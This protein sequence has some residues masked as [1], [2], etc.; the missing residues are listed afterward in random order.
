MNKIHK[1]VT[2]A[3]TFYH[4][5]LNQRHREDGPA[6]IYNSGTEMWYINDRLHRLNGPA[7][8][9]PNSTLENMWWVDGFRYN[10]FKKFIEVVKDRISEEDYFILMLTYGQENA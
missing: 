9:Y 3:G 7:V 6:A 8:V 5:E 10:T 2:S 4:N 1:E